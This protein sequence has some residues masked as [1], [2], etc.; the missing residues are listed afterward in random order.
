MTKVCNRCH[1]EKPVAQFPASNYGRCRVCHNA[2]IRADRAANPDRYKNVELKR[3]YGITLDQYKQMEYDQD[4]KCAICLGSDPKGNGTWHVDHCHDTGKVRALLC[5]TCNQGLGQ[6]KD[7]PD[8][9]LAA[10]A[11]LMAHQPSLTTQ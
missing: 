7:D 8:L 3:K 6:F 9:L 10:I 11:Y 1:V 2:Q 5:N 4:S